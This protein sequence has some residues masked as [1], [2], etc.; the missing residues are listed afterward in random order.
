MYACRIDV[1]LCYISENIYVAIDTE[2]KKAKIMKSIILVLDSKFAAEKI[3]S[4][5]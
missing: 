2:F 3:Y 5:P 1:H 4:P